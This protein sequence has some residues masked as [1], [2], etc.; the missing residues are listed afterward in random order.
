MDILHE[1]E[2][3]THTELAVRLGVVPATVTKMLQ[4]MER[5]GFVVR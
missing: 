4:R 5:A 2:G 3:L 1:N